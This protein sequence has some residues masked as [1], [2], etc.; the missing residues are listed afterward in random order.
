MS[1]RNND[2]Q[3]PGVSD[4]LT[5]SRTTVSGSDVRPLFALEGHED[6]IYHELRVGARATEPDYCAF[7]DQSWTFN[8]AMHWRQ[9]DGTLLCHEPAGPLELTGTGR[10]A[11]WFSDPANVI[12]HAGTELRFEKTAARQREAVVLPGLQTHLAQH[13]RLVV[14]TAAADADWQ[15]CVLVKGRSGRPLVASAW[16]HGPGRVELDLDAAWRA[17]GYTVRF[18][19]LHIAV[20]L[21]SATAEKPAAIRFRATLP[22]RPALVPC[23]PVIRTVAT[24]TRAG[25]PVSVAAVD[26]AVTTVTATIGKQTIALSEIDGVWQGRFAA[27]AAGEHRCR[28]AAVSAAAALEA[29]LMVCVTDS[30]FITYDTAHRSLARDG[31][32]LGPLSGSY[33]GLVYKTGVGTPAERMINGQ[34]MQPAWRWRCSRCLPST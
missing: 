10:V 33:Q 27:L 26:A 28:F 29:E 16:Q 34:A 5:L 1:T 13:P 24:A 25:V 3:I 15:V 22:A 8:R 20:G 2:T 11:D 4:G 9:L 17:A 21:W 18:A 30:R 23:L 19:E 14:E 12:T 32:P 6:E 7:L 31:K